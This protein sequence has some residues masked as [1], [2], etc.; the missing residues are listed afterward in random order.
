[1]LELKHPKV[2][3]IRVMN[4]PIKASNMETTTTTPPPRLGEHTV[5]ILKELG[6]NQQETTEL[7]KRK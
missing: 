4:N 5:D 3:I 2:G 6:Y 1:M 7:L